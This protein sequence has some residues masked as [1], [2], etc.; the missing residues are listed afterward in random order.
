MSIADD[1]MYIC[2]LNPNEIGLCIDIYADKQQAIHVRYK[3]GTGKQLLV[4]GK[5]NKVH[6]PISVPY[7]R[8]DKWAVP[9]S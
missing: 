2:L 3:S 7:D 8:I 9:G 1:N 5:T 4:W 6:D